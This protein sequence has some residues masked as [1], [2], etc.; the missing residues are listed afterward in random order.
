[1]QEERREDMDSDKLATGKVA[2][3]RLEESVSRHV[4]SPSGL[5]LASCGNDDVPATNLTA[6]CLLHRTGS[7]DGQGATTG[8]PFLRTISKSNHHGTA[9]KVST[10]QTPSPA[11]SDYQALGCSNKQQ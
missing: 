9:N 11:N 2:D 7:L 10:L 1:M 4:M 8:S 5:K 3:A 6:H